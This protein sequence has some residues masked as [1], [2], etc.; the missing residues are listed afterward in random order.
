MINAV[1]RNIPDELLA[2]GREV[3]QGKGY[4]DGQ[5]VKKASPT[6][7]KHEKPEA[8]KLAASIR[9]ACE[10]CG[11]HDGMTFS[12]HTELRDGD[13]LASMVAKVLVEEM[14]LKDLHVAAT[15]LGSAQNIFADYMDKGIIVEAQ[16]SGVRGRIGEVISAGKMKKPVT[17]RSHGGR[18]RAV[19]AGEVHIDIAFLAAAS[20]DCCGNARG[21][22]GKN[23]FGS[24]GFAMHDAHY[25]DHTVIVTDTLVPFPNVPCSISSIDVDAVVVV[26]AIGDPAKISTKEA[27]ITENPRELMMA[28]NVAGIIAALPYFKDGF[29]FQTGVG[30]PSLAVNRFLEE[31]MVERGITMSYALGGTT[32]AVC[33]LQDKG[34]VKKI[35]DTQDFDQGAAAH[36]EANP[37]KHIEM[38]L[39]QYA[40]AG[41]KGAFVNKLDYVVLSALEI[42]TKFNV[43]VITGSDGVLRGA[44]GGHPD[45]AAGSKCCII[46]TP[47]TRGRMATVCK[48]VVTVTTPG[49]CVDVLV[50]DFGTAVN[51]ARQDIIDCLDAAGIKHV[52]IEQLQEKAY[53]MV[54]EPD[55]L[56]WEDKV[57]AI[58]EA[59]D[60]TILDVVRQVKPF[61]F[62]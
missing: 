23:N 21:N 4:R 22:G 59:R 31:Y 61:S 27:R 28:K 37:T 43:N 30:G 57:V 48:D 55:P 34:L 50:T 46:V 42:D 6:S 11:A 36:L 9:E 18:P 1:G 26:D 8:D 52:P 32:S 13:Y 20:S 19:E 39:S 40:S 17:I 49:D 25:A 62:D 7:V 45:A 44:P 41:N 54:G 47:L 53:D 12:F 3:Y 5:V 33:A 2:G 16:T 56:E 51:P 58:V 35:C 38:D 29:S 60:G 14:G 15:S 24:M 10:K